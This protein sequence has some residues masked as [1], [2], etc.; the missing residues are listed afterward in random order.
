MILNKLVPEDIDEKIRL[1]NEA[2]MNI[3]TLRDSIKEELKDF[4]WM[5]IRAKVQCQSYEEQLEHIE[6]R[7]Q[8]MSVTN[9][10]R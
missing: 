3:F 9:G 6:K 7:I 4:R 2:G 8:E 5:E 10:I 1:N